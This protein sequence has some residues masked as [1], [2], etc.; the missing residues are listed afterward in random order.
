MTL[1]IHHILSAAVA[2]VI[3]AIASAC[4]TTGKTVHRNTAPSVETISDVK[5]ELRRVI[6]GYG[7]WDRMR[8]PFSL[9]LEKPKSVSVGG[10]A[11]MERGKSI[12]LAFRILGMEIGSLYITNDSIVVIDKIHKR[13]V[14]ETTSNFLKGFP[15][16]MANVQDFLTGRLF[17]LG[18]DNVEFASVTPSEL[19]VSDT[20]S[21]NFCP[22]N[23]PVGMEYGF[24]FYP[25][26]VLKGL[27]ILLTETGRPI[28][29]L[30]SAPEKCGAGDMSPSVKVTYFTGKVPIDATIDWNF[31]KAKWNA[32][33]DLRRPVVTSKYQRIAVNDILKMV[34]KL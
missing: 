23:P 17:I 27:V 24:E 2:S 28:T 32:E 11:I 31:Q 1:K 13:Y 34:S 12:M 14:A 20:Q 30:Y 16:N 3:L 18:K 9:K 7:Q 21:W 6:D 29:C 22:K 33:V 10:T 4:G 5:V 25:T 8:V 19:E 26:D 15:V